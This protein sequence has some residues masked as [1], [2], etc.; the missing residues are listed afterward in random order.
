ML[1]QRR[2]LNPCFPHV[3]V[4]ATITLDCDNFNKKLLHVSI[5][6]KY[7]GR[8]ASTYLCDRMLYFFVEPCHDITQREGNSEPN[9]LY[10]RLLYNLVE[11]FVL[12]S[13]KRRKCSTLI[14]L[15]ICKIIYIFVKLWI[16]MIQSGAI[17]R[18][19]SITSDHIFMNLYSLHSHVHHK[20]CY[21]CVIKSI[22]MC[23]YKHIH[24]LKEGDKA[25]IG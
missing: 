6:W 25:Y 20:M 16:E 18:I 19:Y 7:G 21:Q 3:V 9:Y 14:Y 11:P 22:H 15:F 13:N 10:C 17:N 12:K 4:I 5:F 8:S 2:E 1:P 23:P 24:C